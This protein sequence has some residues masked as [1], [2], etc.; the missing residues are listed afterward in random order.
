MPSIAKRLRSPSGMLWTL[1]KAERRHAK[2]DR[3]YLRL[4]TRGDCNLGLPA[5]GKTWVSTRVTGSGLVRGEESACCGSR[6]E[7]V[8]PDDP[9][10][11]NGS[12]RGPLGSSTALRSGGIDEIFCCWIFWV[13]ILCLRNL[14]RFHVTANAS[15][16]VVHSWCT[17]GCKW[18]LSMQMRT[19]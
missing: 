9:W 19:R 4:G 12:K 8:R 11:G 6:E 2:N 17:M 10:H 14:C 5:L 15:W 16:G 13:R 1:A 7:R 3:H 18:G